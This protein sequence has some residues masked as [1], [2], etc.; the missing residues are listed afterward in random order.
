MSLK[1][2]L[3]P[4]LETELATEAAGL[5]L[6][7]TEYVL[8]LLAVGR[9]PNCKPRTGA[10]LVAYWQSEGLIGT[11]PDITDAPAHAR[12]LR[13]LTSHTTSACG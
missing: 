11:R 2:D 7:L 5:Q 6:T 10:E 1:L 3:P 8:R 9:L 12:S 4:E 13:A